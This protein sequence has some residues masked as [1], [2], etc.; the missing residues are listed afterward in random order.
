MKSAMRAR[1]D[2]TQ[3]AKE[4]LRLGTIRLLLAAVKQREVDERIELDD[5]AVSG[6]IEKLIKQRRDS[7]GQ[8][9]TAGRMDLVNAEQA[10]LA[11]LQAY[12]PEPLSAAEIDAAVAA[13]ITESGA[14]SAKD[15]GKVMGLLKSRLAGRADMGQVSALIKAKLAG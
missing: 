13:A 1:A 8:F 2:E 10:E 3:R 9:Q 5:T 15:M 11:I 6:I 14:T 12:M 7:I 4:T